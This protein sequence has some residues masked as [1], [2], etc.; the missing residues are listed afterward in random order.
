[1]Y[2]HLPSHYA[3]TACQDAVTRVKSFMKRKEKGLARKEQPEVRR[4]SIWLDDHLWERSSLTSLRVG[5]S[6][7]GRAFR[8]PQQ[9][10]MKP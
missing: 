7:D 3:Y 1:M 9:P 8:S 10:P 4:V 2:P 5:L 6:L